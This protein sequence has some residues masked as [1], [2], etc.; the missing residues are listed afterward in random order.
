MVSDKLEKGQKKTSMNS[1]RHIN[2]IDF[3]DVI[4]YDM[5]NAQVLYAGL[6]PGPGKS[7]L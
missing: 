1:A 3:F 7:A 4:L 2:F 5:T 6:D